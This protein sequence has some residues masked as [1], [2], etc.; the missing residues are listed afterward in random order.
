MDS[1]I[2]IASIIKESMDCSTPQDRRR[3]MHDCRR[4]VEYERQRGLHGLLNGDRRE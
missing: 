3:R 1:L 2:T 4:K